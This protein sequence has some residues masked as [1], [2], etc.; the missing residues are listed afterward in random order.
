MQQGLS[1]NRYLAQ[2]LM[3]MPLCLM[4]IPQSVNIN[5]QDQNILL[6]VI[7][8]ID[9]CISICLLALGFGRASSQRIRLCKRNRHSPRD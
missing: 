7:H 1:K 5:I 4:K 3:Y 2:R 6:S 9:I 8:L